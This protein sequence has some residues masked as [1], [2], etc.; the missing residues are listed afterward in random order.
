MLMLK[1]RLS[2]V[3]SMTECKAMSNVSALAV[4]TVKQVTLFNYA[5]LMGEINCSKVQLL[6]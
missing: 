4:F 5:D 6:L 1:Y 3:A 2:F